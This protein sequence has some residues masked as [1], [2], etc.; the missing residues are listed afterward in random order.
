MTGKEL[1]ETYPKAAS[2]IKKQ[3]LNNLLESL[4][5]EALPED[6]KT[7]VREQGLSDERAEELID[8]SPRAL[9]DIFDLYKIYIGTIVDE[10][11]GFWWTVNNTKSTVGYEFRIN[12]DKSAIEEAFKLLNDKL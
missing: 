5:D 3:L 1:L 2:E 10:L 7:Y 8:T 11:N 4:S 9:F 6:F 12:C